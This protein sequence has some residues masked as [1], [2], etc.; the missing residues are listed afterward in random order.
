MDRSTVVMLHA[1]GASSRPW[2]DVVAGLGPGVTC[3]TPDLPGFGDRADMG[4]CGVSGTVDWFAGHVADRASGP[5]LSV[6]H[7]MGGKFATL[8][9]AR[10][11][12]TAGVLPN[13]RGVVV[14]AASP[15]APEPM[16]EARR[17]EMLGWFAEGAPGEC[18][19]TKFVTDNVARA[20]PS[21][22][23]ADAVADVRRSAPA[24]WIDW[25]ARGAREDW[26]GRV[27][28]LDLPATIV[29]GAADG[30]LGEAN[31]RRLNLPHYA[32]ASLEI[33]PDAAHL[34]PYEQPEAVAEL[35]LGTLR[36]AG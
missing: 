29:A 10:A 27:G 17:A 31:Q 5:M 14:L 32:R 18:E 21:D 12:R 2:A 16:E 30:D 25:L 20:L 22:R 26:S 7:S 1:L 36:R 6:G 3:L 23:Q 35:I 13:V 8:L 33:V 15:P 34:L 11:T 19:A 9:A 28:V 24:A 4:A